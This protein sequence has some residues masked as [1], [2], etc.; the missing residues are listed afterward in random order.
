MDGPGVLVTGAN[1]FIGNALARSL[2][3]KFA[4]KR[5]LRKKR[6]D[7]GKQDDRDGDEDECFYYEALEKTDWRPALDSVEAVVHLAARVHVLKEYAADPLASYVKAN[8]E[9]TLALAEQAAKNGVRRFVF[10]STIGVNGRTTAGT[11]FTE[12]A[13]PAPHDDYSRSKLMA[14]TGLKKLASESSMEVVIIRPPLVYGPNVKANFLRLLNLV[15]KGWPLP[16]ANAENRRS[17]IALDNLVSAIDSCISHPAAAGQ[18]FLV[19]DGEDLSI[20]GLV[21]KIARHM[22]KPARLFPFPSATAK[23]LLRM[24]GKSNLYDQLWGSLAVDSGKIRRE[25]GRAPPVSVEWE[26]KKTVE[27]YLD[28]H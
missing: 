3:D 27:W 12:D 4:V 9:G 7:E 19:S 11:A 16:L 17:F 10:V 22:R 24:A 8:C 6:R 13:P 5:A 28:D 25:L 18:V 2:K 14:E 23:A 1:G 26:L 21:R 20:S 15:R